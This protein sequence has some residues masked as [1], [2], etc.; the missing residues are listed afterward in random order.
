MF[1]HPLHKN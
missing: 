1:D